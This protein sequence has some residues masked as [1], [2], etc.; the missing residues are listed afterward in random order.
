MRIIL[1]RHG[2]TDWNQQRRIQGAG[3]DTELNETGKEQARSLAELLK[4]EDI[5]AIY[6]SPLKRSLATAET[7]SQ[8]H[9]IGVT[10]VP[11]L[12]EIEAG[13][14]EGMPLASFDSTL[15]QFLLDWQQ[16]NG[17][18]KLPGGESLVDLSDRTWAVIKDIMNKHS[19]GTVVVV[20]HYFV[21]L[22][23]ICRALDL[24]VSHLRRLRAS[25]GSISVL[26]FEDNKARLVVL[27]DTCHLPQR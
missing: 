2:A 11:D 25:T 27:N 17:A 7:I 10:V 19:N 16:G 8:Y 5:V 23:T 26:D 13:E 1:V 21:I 22:T 20:S 14:F 24:P 3:S 6:S 18:A 9:P 4:K 15:D 12:R